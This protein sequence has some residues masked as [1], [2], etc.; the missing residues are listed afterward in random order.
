MKSDSHT[1]P[2]YPSV[3]EDSILFFKTATDSVSLNSDDHI[4][5]LKKELNN[6]FNLFS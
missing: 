5:T 1:S 3:Q 4:V 6:R 2:P